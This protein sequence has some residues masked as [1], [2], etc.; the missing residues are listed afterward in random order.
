MFDPNL[1]DEFRGLVNLA[2]RLLDEKTGLDYLRLVLYYFTGATDRI[3]K[4]ELADVLE[5][6]E[7]QGAKVMATIAEEYRAEGREQAKLEIAVRMLPILADE[8]ISNILNIPIDEVRKIRAK[9][10]KSAYP[11]TA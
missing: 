2:S 9:H 10:G 4:N 5:E 8:T 7:T 6:Q 3:S 11:F 1:R